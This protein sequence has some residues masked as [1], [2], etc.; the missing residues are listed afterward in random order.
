MTRVG[1][2]GSLVPPVP[3]PLL[4]ALL[5][6]VAVVELVEPVSAPP[7]PEAEVVVST[8]SPWSRAQA[9]R[10]YCEEEQRGEVSAKSKKH[11]PS[12]PC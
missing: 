5:V 8:P 6:P 1:P 10:R 7:V 11:A 3:D 12:L 2:G 4:E 9:P